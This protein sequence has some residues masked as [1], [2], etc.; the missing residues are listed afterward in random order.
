MTIIVGSTNPAKVNAV[1]A[2]FSSDK[3][4]AKNVPSNVSSQP[5]SDEETREGAINRAIQCMK[6]AP[7]AIGIGLEGGVMY[8]GEQLFLCNWGA[9]VTSIGEIYT[10]SGARILLP[11]TIKEQLEQGI[12]LGEVMDMYMNKSGIRYQEGAIGIFTNDL[13]SRKDMFTHV[14]TLLKGQWEFGEK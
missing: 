12:E 14:V 6:S 7:N 10:A 4:I 1:Q 2:V 8:V 11:D 5:F 13:I 9:L 3:V